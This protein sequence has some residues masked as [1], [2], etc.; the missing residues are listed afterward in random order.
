MILH[1]SAI[2]HYKNTA[3]FV[4]QY[5]CYSDFLKYISHLISGVENNFMKGV[6]AYIYLQNISVCIMLH[7]LLG[8]WF[9][10]GRIFL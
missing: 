9:K 1:F 5:N 2:L 6:L 4:F 8:K 7:L 3:I 10:G